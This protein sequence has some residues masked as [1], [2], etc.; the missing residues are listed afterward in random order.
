MNL[1]N[2]KERFFEKRFLILLGISLALSLIATRITY[3]ASKYIHR[4]FNIPPV[5]KDLVWEKI[6]YIPVLWLAEVFMLVSLAYMI[7]WA[8]F[9]K[10]N[11][12]YLP[13]AVT[14]FAIFHFF[15]AI[16]IV[17]TPLG[18]PYTYD[19]I[20]HAGAESVFMFGAFPSGHLAIPALTFLI[21]KRKT[22][23]ILTLL[24]G[25]LLLLSRGHYSID[26]VGT[27]LLAYPIYRFSKLYLKKHFIK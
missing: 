12:Y 20:L 27:V 19:G 18:F 2:L 23:L 16:L 24:V 22:A 15:R 9:I 1:K 13:Y 8:F 3:G 10:K 25:A 6:P 7:F 26:L 4:V 14:L 21:T 17:L 11:K 5:V